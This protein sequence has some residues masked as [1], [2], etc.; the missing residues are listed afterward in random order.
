[1]RVILTLPL[2]DKPPRPPASALSSAPADGFYLF[3][4]GGKKENVIKR[5]R[6][7]WIYGGSKAL[8]HMA[9]AVSKCLL[10]EKEAGGMLLISSSHPG[11]RMRG[12]RGRGRGP[13]RRMRV[14]TGVHRA[15]P[16]TDKGFRF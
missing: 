15:L 5:N 4:F 1:M 2:V 3:T 12:S 9:V 7:R 10:S 6:A 8:Y 14:G 16:L 11:E 13:A